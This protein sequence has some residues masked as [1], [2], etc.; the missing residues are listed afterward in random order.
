MSYG[1]KIL[2]ESWLWSKQQL[3]PVGNYSIDNFIKIPKCLYNF[4]CPSDFLDENGNIIVPINIFRKSWNVSILNKDNIFQYKYD[5]IETDIIIHASR[6]ITLKTYDDSW[7]SILDFST[8]QE[9]NEAYI[10]LCQV[11][12]V[13]MLM[14]DNRYLGLLSNYYTKE[15]SDELIISQLIHF[16]EDYSTKEEADIKLIDSIITYLRTLK[17]I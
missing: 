6:F 14:L 9:A 4:E 12:K 10:K 15:E 16:L 17:T 8:E 3:H 7:N 13:Y 1:D 5:P 2:Y 11:K